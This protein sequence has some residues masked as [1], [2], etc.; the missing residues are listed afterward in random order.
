MFNPGLTSPN[1]Y[2]PHSASSVLADNNFS[3]RNF[4]FFSTR[5]Y[6]SSC[7]CRCNTSFKLIT[8]NA[9]TLKNKILEKLSKNNSFECLV[10]TWKMYAEMYNKYLSW[11][12]Y[13]EQF[14]NVKHSNK[15]PK[16]NPK[17]EAT[18]N[19]T[20]K[21]PFTHDNLTEYISKCT[22]KVII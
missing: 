5:K 3:N 7:R 22:R 15:N 4:S 16:V 8:A 14:W 17:S 9:L 10:W 6:P 11:I 1:L 18:H 19:E 21:V 13:V 2:H 20:Y 12:Y